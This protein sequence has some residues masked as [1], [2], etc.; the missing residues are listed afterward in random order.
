MS[1]FV[2]LYSICFVSRFGIM[3]GDSSTVMG[4]ALTGIR[5]CESAYSKVRQHAA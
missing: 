3:I 2:L 4:A 1:V 5:S